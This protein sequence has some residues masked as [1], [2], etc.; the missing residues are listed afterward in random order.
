M[1]D[2]NGGGGGAADLLLNNGGGGGGEGGNG[3]EGGG[4]SWR[5]ALP[6]DLKG[7]AALANFADIPSLAKGYVETKALA[8]SRQVDY[9]TPEGLKVFA[10]A[11]RPAEASAYEIS[12]DADGNATALGDAFRAFA[13]ERGM[14]AGWVKDIDGFFNAQ[15]GAA[16]AAQN[17]ASVKEVDTLKGQLG[18]A[19][20]DAQLA[21]VQAML[22]KFGVELS[23]QDLTQ[24]DLKLGSGNLL[25]FMFEMADRV[26]DPAPIDGAQGG[27]TGGGAMTPEQAQAKWNELNKDAAWRAE[28]MKDGTAQ[29]KEYQRLQNLIIAGRSAARAKKPG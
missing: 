25:R 4:A 17:A 2:A 20:F 16:I 12:G 21:K 3:G 14:P 22:P 5:D 19:K 9:S 26:G 10:D 28:A 15:A 11:V 1:S 8:T 13:H 6:D 7:N 24:L 23:E 29:N 18:A 27:E